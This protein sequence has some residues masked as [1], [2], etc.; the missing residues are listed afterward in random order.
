MYTTGE[1]GSVLTNKTL[2]NTIATSFRDWGRDCWCP[3]GTD[4]TCEKRFDWNLGKLPK[5]YDHKYI[6]SHLGYNLKATDFQAAIGLAQLNR[7]QSF[8]EKR[9]ENFKVF[10][11]TLIKM[12]LEEELILPVAT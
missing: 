8:I 11:D 4:N 6:Y 12:G 2:L 7:A 9:Q 10:K 3:A 1:G 5:G